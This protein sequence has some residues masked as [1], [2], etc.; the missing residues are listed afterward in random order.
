MRVAVLNATRILYEGNAKEVI[1]PGEE[2][3]FAVLDFHQ[4]LLSSLTKGIIRI[5]AS[6]AMRRTGRISEK[7][8]QVNIGINKGLAKMIR[9]ELV[10]MV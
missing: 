6:E 8:F 5:I 1:L 9:N 2:G 10:I 4:A 3:E 7:L